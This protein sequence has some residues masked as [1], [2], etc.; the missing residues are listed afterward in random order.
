M[1]TSSYEFN[2]VVYVQWEEYS[3]CYTTE[4]YEDTLSRIKAKEIIRRHFCFLF[5][6]L[7]LFI[8]SWKFFIIKT[9]AYDMMRTQRA[10]LSFKV[11]NRVRS[12]A[13]TGFLQQNF[14][15]ITG[16][17]MC[18]SIFLIKNFKATLLKTDSNT[19]VFLI[20]FWNF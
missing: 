18:Y 4:T 14:A 17:Y 8:C 3:I 5:S 6:L 15:I 11:R 1:N 16:I 10:H 2:V 9:H 19:G 12:K 20:T 13:A 7:Y